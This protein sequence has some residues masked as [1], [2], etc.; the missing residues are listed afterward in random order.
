[1]KA[2][3]H[4]LLV[5]MNMIS[6]R[7]TPQAYFLSF[8][9]SSNLMWKFTSFNC[10]LS[11]AFLTYLL[12]MPPS[13]LSYLSLFRNCWRQSLA[14]FS[15]TLRFCSASA[16]SRSENASSLN[17]KMTKMLSRMH[18]TGTELIFDRVIWTLSFPM[19][20]YTNRI[21]MSSLSKN[22]LFRLMF[23]ILKFPPNTSTVRLSF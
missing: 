10:R 7:V 21:G 11:I 3:C 14:Y 19:E 1:M 18:S 13:F 23:S 16:C 15:I 5:V 12:N 6:S 20:L 8:V 17:S 22:S 4:S 2:G 9:F